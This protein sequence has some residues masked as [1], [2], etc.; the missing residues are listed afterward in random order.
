MLRN[1]ALREHDLTTQGIRK[2]VADSKALSGAQ[3][4]KVSR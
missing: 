1:L 3:R 2:F 4:K